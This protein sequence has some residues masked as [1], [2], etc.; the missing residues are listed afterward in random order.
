MKKL[1]VNLYVS[2]IRNKEKRRA[3][4]E[5]LLARTDKPT[6][7]PPNKMI[8]ELFKIVHFIALILGKKSERCREFN[9]IHIITFRPF[10]PEGGKG[11]GGAVQSCNKVLF[12]ESFNSIP[13]KYSFRE[14]NKHWLDTNSDLR[15]LFGAVEFVKQKTKNDKHCAYI[16]H[17]YGTAFGLYL[18]GKK[19]IQ[20]TEL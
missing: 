17:D 20:Q 4:R 7:K 3:V 18:L 8:A 6:E 14:D 19:H 11:G 16:T 9:N 13:I 10:S 1:L 12:G 5:I 2:I 15:D